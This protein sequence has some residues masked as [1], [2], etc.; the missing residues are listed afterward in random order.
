MYWKKFSC[1]LVW[2]EYNI[3][4]V[5]W[6]VGR[7]II[8]RFQSL[9]KYHTLLQ[10]VQFPSLSSNTNSPR[11]SAVFCSISLTTLGESNFHHK[12]KKAM[13]VIVS[14][15]VFAEW[16]H[17]NL[18]ERRWKVEMTWTGL[19]VFW[20]N[21]SKWLQAMGN[22]TKVTMWNSAYITTPLCCKNSSF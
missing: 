16:R 21:T 10:L 22:Y 11:H 20:R 1:W 13:F 2:H 3:M 14:R 6:E 17:S 9:K 19:Q 15:I 8:L 4:D 12:C 5:L 7:E 18:G